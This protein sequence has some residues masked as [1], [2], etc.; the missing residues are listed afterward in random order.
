L[1]YGSLSSCITRYCDAFLPALAN[2]S[3][4]SRMA[5]FEKII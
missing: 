3:L 4:W 1:E 5:Q 2:K